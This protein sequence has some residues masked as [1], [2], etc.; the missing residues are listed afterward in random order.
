MGRSIDT[1]LPGFTDTWTEATIGQPCNMRS[2]RPKRRAI[3]GQYWVVDMGSVTRDAALVVTRKTN[4]STDILQSGELVM[5]KDDIGGGNIIGRTGLIQRADTYVLA[6]HVYALTP[7]NIDPEF[8]NLAI[9][10]YR[11][12]M[13]LRSKATG[14]AQLGLSRRS[15]L[16]QPVSFPSDL[17]EQR[18]IASTIRDASSQVDAL[19]GRLQKASAIKTGMMQQL[20]TGRTRL[21]EEAV[22]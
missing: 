22:S 5:P 18:A 1:R 2:G 8:L 3:D 12:N 11:V 20:L 13:S 9:N 7:R 4:D 19:Q 10:S 14:S 6:D 21:P 16:D 17:Q 15:V